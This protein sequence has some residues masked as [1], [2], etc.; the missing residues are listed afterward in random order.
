M[1]VLRG[2]DKLPEADLRH[3]SYAHKGRGGRIAQG[4]NRSHG[5]TLGNSLKI[6]GHFLSAGRTPLVQAGRPP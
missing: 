5:M 4:R 2:V 1:L 3:G 6:K